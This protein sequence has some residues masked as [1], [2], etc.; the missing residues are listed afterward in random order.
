MLVPRPA[1][2]QDGQG[3]NDHPLF[4]RMPNFEIYNCKTI[5]FD[6]VSFAKPGLKHW[7]VEKP[8]DYETVE[9]KV[10]VVSY[11]LKDGVT[12]PSA[13]QIIRNFENATRAAGGTVLGDFVGPFA[14]GIKEDMERFMKDAPGGSSYTRYANLKFTKGASETWVNVAASD[15]YHD[16]NIVVVERQAMAQDVCVNEMVDRLNKDG[17]IALYVNF[18]TNKTTIKPDSAK[19]LDDAAAV[20]K[21]APALSILV[22][23][24]TDNVGTPEANL[25]LSDERAKAVTA[26]LVERGI[27]AS[28][29]TP[30]GF[31]QTQPVAD[32]RLEEGRAKNRRVELVKK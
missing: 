11:K 3:C 12:P 22:G 9:G 32:N 15:E 2:A 14:A 26:A 18:D 5:E 13:L 30:Q 6:A 21:A 25:K 24:H 31:G 4:N 10:F 27:A 20:L 16:Y 7:D 1:A 19:I 17:F 8:D 29:L 28:R 23:G